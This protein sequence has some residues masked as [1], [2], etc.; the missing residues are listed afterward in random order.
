MCYD[1]VFFPSL[2]KDLFFVYECFANMYVCTSYACLDLQR[3][4]EGIGSPGTGV[5]VIISYHVGAGN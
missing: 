5:W 4:G 1:L 2:L 3:S